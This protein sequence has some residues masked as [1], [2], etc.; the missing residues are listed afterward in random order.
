MQ[1]LNEFSGVIDLDPLTGWMTDQG[2]GTGPIDGFNAPS[3]TGNCAQSVTRC[4]ILVG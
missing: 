2:L 1:K 3:L 4:L